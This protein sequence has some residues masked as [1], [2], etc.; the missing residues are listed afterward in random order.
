MMK[1]SYKSVQFELVLNIEGLTNIPQLDNNIC[2]MQRS[3]SN[4]RLKTFKQQQHHKD[5]FTSKKYPV[6]DHKCSFEADGKSVIPVKLYADPKDNYTLSDKWLQITFII[7]DPQTNSKEKLGLLELNLTE[8]VNERSPVNLR[9]LL[10]KSKTNSI[11]K[12][13]IFVK[14]LQSDQSFEYNIPNKTTSQIY[15]GLKDTIVEHHVSDSKSGADQMLCDIV[16]KTFRFTWQY[17]E[18]RYE[19]YTPSE[20][21][22]DIVE[23]NGNGWKKNDEGMNY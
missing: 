17:I 4:S 3:I 2:Y 18:S 7:E 14:H 16:N 1:L 22:R 19:E 12:F 10:K 23:Y 11:L 21:I 6:K 13:S 5:T 9:Y 15:Q 8:Y 20:C